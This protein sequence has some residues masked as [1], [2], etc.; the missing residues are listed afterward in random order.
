MAYTYRPRVPYINIVGE[1]DYHTASFKLTANDNIIDV[2]ETIPRSVREFP[3]DRWKDLKE[4][5][6]R[7]RLALIEQGEFDADAD[8]PHSPY[9]HLRRLFFQDVPIKLVLANPWKRFGGFYATSNPQYWEWA[10][11]LLSDGD[12]VFD[13]GFFI[14]PEWLA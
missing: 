5:F 11:G 14:K 10:S 6:M 3:P 2:Y 1:N 13:W 12:P 7:E 4:E 8:H 9:D